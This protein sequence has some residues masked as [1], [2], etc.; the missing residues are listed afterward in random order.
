MNYY[1]GVDLD[2][3]M[4]LYSYISTYHST[5]SELREVYMEADSALQK[6]VRNHH[7]KIALY[8]TAFNLSIYAV[9]YGTS[10]LIQ[11]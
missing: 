1:K 7:L 2:R 3:N 9:F 6:L 11:G 4:N 10:I 5:D 8:K